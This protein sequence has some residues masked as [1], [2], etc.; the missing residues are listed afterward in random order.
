M[1]KRWTAP[2]Y[3]DTQMCRRTR[4]ILKEKKRKPKNPS[5]DIQGCVELKTGISLLVE[6]GLHDYAPNPNCIAVHGP[7]GL[8][9]NRASR[10][11]P[12]QEDW[13]LP[14][15]PTEEEPRV[16]KTWEQ[17]ERSAESWSLADYKGVRELVF[18]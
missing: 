6:T 2:S 13:L 14:F 18:K 15:F 5:S 4:R 10:G 7:G 8:L 12:A 3:A 17:R 9:P 11:L 16:R 1:P